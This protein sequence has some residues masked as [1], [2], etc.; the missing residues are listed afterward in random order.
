MTMNPYLKLAGWLL[1]IIALIILGPLAVIW[2]LNTLF[3]M[4]IVYTFWTWLAVVVLQTMI[5]SA[6][7]KK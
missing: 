3:S 4:G 5:F 7:F 2:A 1:F 6:H